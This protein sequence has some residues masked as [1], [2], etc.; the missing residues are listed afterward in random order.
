M[1]NPN[2]ANGSV[3]DLAD[4]LIRR[5]RSAGADAADVLVVDQTSV[6]N[7]Q[8]LGRTEKLE[9]SESSDVGLR[10][11][12]GRQM[13]VA[14]T[15][16]RSPDALEALVD[17][18]MA[19]ARVVPE[20]AY[21]GI[22]DPD[23]LTTEMPDLDQ[24]DPQEPAPGDLVVR[25]KAAEAAALAVDGVTNSQGASASWGRSAVHLAASNGFSGGYSM[26][27]SSI[28]VAVIAG[29]GTGMETD[30]DYTTA[31]HAGDLEDAE[32]VGRRAAERAVRRLGAEKLASQPLPVVYDP[33]VSSSLLRH[34]ISAISGS[35]IAR[36]TSFLLDQMGE[37]VLADDLSVVE[38]PFLV[39]GL[40][41]RP[42][43]AEGLGPQ[44]WRLIDQGRLTTWLLDLRSARQLGLAPTGHASRGT[45][46]PP[47]P[48]P[49]NLWLDG[50]TVPRDDLLAGVGRGLYV[51]Q[52]LGSSVSMV[53][54]DYSR[55][56]SGF[57]IEDGEIAG[58]VNEVTIA[59]NLK[60][61][62]RAITA[63]DDL[64]RKTGIDA[65]TLRVDGMTVAGA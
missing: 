9:R 45:G 50:K 33:R 54:G 58:P 57:L 12:I 27:R 11:F 59:G 53:T 52:L 43:D 51:T 47:S 15:T 18:A 61:M 38:D 7:D 25:A 22:A 29:S 39:R 6:T 34:L 10:V 16:D 2:A 40:R 28:S 23:Q 24:A 60:D 13:A 55:G 14:S 30:Y 62:F 21:G 5:A 20:D 49:T 35:A 32:G 48:S 1:T 41:S 44:S 3:A 8:R 63:A 36:K 65:P 64:E 37:S 46:G 4:T 56:A 19:M 26:T 31:I 17:R 42:F